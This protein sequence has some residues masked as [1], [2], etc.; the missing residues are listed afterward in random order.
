MRTL[1]L[2]ATTGTVFGINVL[3]SRYL[4]WDSYLDLAAGRQVVRHGIPHDEVWTVAARAEWIDQQW[5]A[6]L[7]YYAAWAAGG[8][9]AVAA[10]SCALVAGAFGALCLFMM[11]RSVAP[12]RAF[13]WTMLAFAGCMGNTVIRA[14]SFAYP[15]FVVLG[16]IL[17]S[18]PYG[19][20]VKLA[21]IPLL[22]ALWTNLHGTVILGA[23]LAVLWSMWRAT[24][25]FRLGERGLALVH[26]GVAA[27]SVAAVFANPYGFSIVRYYSALLGN[28]TVSKYIVEWAPPSLGS[29]FSIM[30]FVI[31][32]LVVAT[33]AF[34]IARG[35]RPQGSLVAGVAILALLAA[36]G[37]RYQAWFV[38]AGV[39]LGA[40]TLAA[41]E[42]PLAFAP[43]LVKTIAVTATGFALVATLVLVGTPEAKFESLTPRAEIAAA[44]AYASAHPNAS[45]L[46]DE[47]SSS[48]LLWRYPSTAGK[49]GFDARLEQYP[50]TSLRQW[51]SFL[52]QDSPD[53]L[54]AT[55]GFDVIVVT[56]ADHP[57]LARRL[58]RLRGWR[59]LAGSEEG[60][61]VV[62]R[63]A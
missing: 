29:P 3:F 49:V 58:L 19:S 7:A 25:A 16:W 60:I 41:V 33:T 47:N 31:A 8:Y 23:A 28:R 44:A 4:F 12:Q 50:Q 57:E 14:Q 46:A 35:V 43:R 15:L 53:W 45:I 13:M 59:T 52:T 56:R 17:L 32:I 39:A 2:A 34:A 61:V 1:W 30:F 9:A 36:T 21:L 26:A 63:A 51:F 54:R 11:S 27:A 37:V 18:T 5:L 10:L 55:R 20:R 22:I 62:R 6:H 38:I 24:R 48:A 42:S 40:T